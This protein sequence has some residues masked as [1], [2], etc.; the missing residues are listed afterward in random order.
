MEAAARYSFIL[1]HPQPLTFPV[2]QVIPST[3]SLLC[4]LG[5]SIFQTPLIGLFHTHSCFPLFTHSPPHSRFRPRGLLLELSPSLHF[6]VL[7][8]I[9]RDL[10][11]KID[12]PASC[13][14]AP[15]ESNQNNNNHNNTNDNNKPPHRHRSSTPTHTKTTE[16]KTNLLCC[17]CWRG[18]T[19]TQP[20][21]IPQLR[22]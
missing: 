9:S 10:Q 6:L 5:K 15:A 1:F 2:A 22:T 12:F 16:Y 8:P 4:S 3:A 7:P 17:Y 20:R 21:S 11:H 19:G 13:R 18:W 14:T